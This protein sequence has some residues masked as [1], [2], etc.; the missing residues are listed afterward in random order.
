MRHTEL[1]PPV[2]EA[3]QRAVDALARLYDE[4]DQARW[5][6]ADR[7]VEHALTLTMHTLPQ[8]RASCRPALAH[9]L[10]LRTALRDDESA[11]APYIDKAQETARAV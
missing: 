8:A 11:L 1:P 2:A 9:L 4:P 7:S 10:Q 5:R 6:D 3:M